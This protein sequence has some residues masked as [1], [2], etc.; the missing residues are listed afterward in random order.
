MM[1]D[2]TGFVFY[3][4]GVYPEYDVNIFEQSVQHRIIVFS[5]DIVRYYA[6][7]MQL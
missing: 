3:G 4:I 7:I 5:I 6:I 2:H 1:N